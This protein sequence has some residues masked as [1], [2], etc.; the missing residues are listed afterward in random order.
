MVRS[1]D[2]LELYNAEI[3]DSVRDTAAPRHVLLEEGITPKTDDDGGFEIGLGTVFGLIWGSI[4]LFFAYNISKGWR[5]GV[6][7]SAKPPVIAMPRTRPEWKQNL[8]E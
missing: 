3:Y 1:R 6:A 7:E 2:D 8:D 4:V 5:E